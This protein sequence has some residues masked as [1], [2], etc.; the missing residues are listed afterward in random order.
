MENLSTSD[1]YITYRP[2]S[3]YNGPDEFDFQVNDGTDNSNV[4]TIDVTVNPVN[5]APVAKDDKYSIFQ[6]SGPTT[7]AVG[8]ND[9]D[10]ELDAFSNSLC[11]DSVSYPVIG[12]VGIAQACG[13]NLMTL[14]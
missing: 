1:G 9:S 5:D 3:N 7:L 4:A 8:Q 14:N 12:S 6:D 11:I 13:G 2:P 10:V